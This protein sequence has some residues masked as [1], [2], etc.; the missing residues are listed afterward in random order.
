MDWLIELPVWLQLAATLAFVVPLAGVGAWV[1]LWLLDT[2]SLRSPRRK[3][4]N[5]GHD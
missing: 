1:L 3:G 4:N 5:R 2:V